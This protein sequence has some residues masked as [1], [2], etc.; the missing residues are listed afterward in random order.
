MSERENLFRPIHKGIRSMLY[1]LGSRLQTTDFADEDAS[2]R[3]IDRLRRD[4]ESSMSNCVL[5]LLS[6]HSRHEEQEV[7]SRLAPHDDDLVRIV[8]KEHLEISRRVYALTRT[9]DEVLAADTTDRR[10]E[11]GDRL[12]LEANDLFSYYFAHLNN[13]EALIV[14][15]MWER[16]T[17]DELRDIRAKFWDALPD[18]LFEIW[19][20]WTLPSLN[21][22]ELVTLF[23][24]LKRTPDRCRYPE[25]VRMARAILDPPALKSLEDRVGLGNS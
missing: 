1:E 6:S 9:S 2:R 20:R 15:V 11:I 5:C 18:P 12:N 21:I 14:P 24:G 4:L 23:S 7:F 25:W 19:L 22:H 8:L 13:E 17:D 16:F 3:L 10:I